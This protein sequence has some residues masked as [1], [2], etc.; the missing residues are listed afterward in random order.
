MMSEQDL[1]KNL[2]VVRSRINAA[3]QR[4]GRPPNTVRLV[5]VTKTKPVDMV[6]QAINADLTDLGENYVQEFQAKYEQVAAAGYRPTWH[7]IGQL[8]TKKVKYLNN[9]VQWIHSLDRERVLNEIERRFERP[10]NCLIEV[11]IGEE[12][13]KGG[14]APGD[15]NEFALAA[16][17]RSKCVLRGLMCVPPAVDD[18]E[19]ARPFFRDLT[20]LFREMKAFLE[21]R[22][23]DTSLVTE[24][25]MGMS[26]DFE[27]AIEEGATMV[28]VGTAIFGARL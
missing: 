12:P 16:A 26:H 17:A 6:I 27:Q 8:Q 18:P 2:S 1:N 25:S 23:V 10:V 22:D 21:A 13:E 11:N 28:R 4:S 20:R 7:F 9:R 19:D 24:L 5:G 14:I 15:L 3:C